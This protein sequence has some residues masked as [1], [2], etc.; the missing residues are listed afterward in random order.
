MLTNLELHIK[1][2]GTDSF[3]KIPVKIKIILS[4][5]CSFGLEKHIMH[6]QRVDL[7]LFYFEKN[8]TF[9]SS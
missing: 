8:G 7:G 1:I 5:S 9:Y 4:V 6:A 2:M 3:K